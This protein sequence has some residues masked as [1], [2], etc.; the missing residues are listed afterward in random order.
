MRNILSDQIPFF[1]EGP[2]LFPRVTEPS[3]LNTKWGEEVTT[4]TTKR[5]RWRETSLS[6]ASDSTLNHNGIFVQSTRAVQKPCCH[7]PAV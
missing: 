2:E 7:L 1:Q 4:E 5:C 6:A 3:S